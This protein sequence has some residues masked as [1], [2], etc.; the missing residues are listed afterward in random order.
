MGEGLEQHRRLLYAKAGIT[1][2]VCW[3][4][5]PSS[6]VQN[7]YRFQREKGKDLHFFYLPSIVA[8]LCRQG[9]ISTMTS[10][11]TT[12]MDTNQIYLHPYTSY[13]LSLKHLQVTELNNRVQWDTCRFFALQ[14]QGCYH[15]SKPWTRRREDATTT[16]TRQVIVL[17]IKYNS[18]SFVQPIFLEFVTFMYHMLMV[19]RKCIETIEPLSDMRL[20]VFFNSIQ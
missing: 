10:C 6:F 20:D 3:S 19:F 16:S 11:F 8:S 12:T 4:K 18:V 1:V 9:D 17:R 2:S 5:A 14:H 15:S 13:Q 7:I